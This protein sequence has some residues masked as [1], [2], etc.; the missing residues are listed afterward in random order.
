MN[1]KG[2]VDDPDADLAHFS[3]ASRKNDEVEVVQYSQVLANN[4]KYTYCVETSFAVAG[5]YLVM[6]R[7]RDQKGRTGEAILEV[8]VDPAAGQVATPIAKPR[9]GPIPEAVVVEITT[10]TAGATVE[11]QFK[12]LTD[13]FTAPTTGWLTYTN[14]VVVDPNK[15]LWTRATKSGSPTSEVIAEVYYLADYAQSL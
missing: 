7:A 1:F 8:T 4:I 9:S 2:V 6:A 15:V 11:Y 12:E 13:D 14:T 3:L 5:T 10:A